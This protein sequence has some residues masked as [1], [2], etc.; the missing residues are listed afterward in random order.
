MTTIVN[1]KTGEVGE[2]QPVNAQDIDGSPAWYVMIR[3]KKPVRFAIWNQ[4][5]CEVIGD[6]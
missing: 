2:L 5:I 1:T 6:E 4:N 3:D